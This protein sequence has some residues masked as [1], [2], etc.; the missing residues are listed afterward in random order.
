MNRLLTSCRTAAFTR[1]R[2]PGLW[3]WHLTKVGM[4]L[5]VILMSSCTVFVFNEDK[6]AKKDSGDS[7]SIVI[8][9]SAEQDIRQ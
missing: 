3:R 1:R 4:G 2:S 7:I 8:T 9:H 5:M 6:N